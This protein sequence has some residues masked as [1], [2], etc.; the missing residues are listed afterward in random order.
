MLR[1]VFFAALIW[2][3]GCSVIRHSGA[4]RCEVLNIAL[5]SNIVQ[6]EFVLCDSKGTYILFDKDGSKRLCNPISTCTSVVG[7]SNDAKYDKLDPNNNFLN[8][9]EHVIVLYDTKVVGREYTINLWKPYSGAVV[10]M[11]YEK[12][13]DTFILVDYTIGSF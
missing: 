8:I 2:S 7:E 11:T 9:D 5:N 1:T 4:V 3:A 12:N 13:K 10:N 6:R